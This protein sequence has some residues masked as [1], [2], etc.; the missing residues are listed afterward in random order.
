MD[1]LHFRICPSE[2]TSEERVKKMHGKVRL[3]FKLGCHTG[4]KSSN[5]VTQHCNC[6]ASILHGSNNENDDALRAKVQQLRDTMMDGKGSWDELWKNET[7][8]WDLGKPTPVL[9]AELRKQRPGTIFQRDTQH[10]GEPMRALVPGCGSAC[11]L[12]IIAKHFQMMEKNSGNRNAVP[13]VTGLDISSHSIDQARNQIIPLIKNE[14]TLIDDPVIPIGHLQKDLMLGD[15]FSQHD[16]WMH[17]HSVERKGNSEEEAKDTLITQD[18]RCDFIH[19]CTFF[20]ASPPNQRGQWA[21]RMST[22]LKPKTGK[23]LTL[24]FPALE[25]LDKDEVQLKGLPF[26]VTIKD[27]VQEL[28]PLGFQITEGP[29]KSKFTVESGTG[30]EFVCWWTCAPQKQKTMIRHF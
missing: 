20:C 7:M 8:P 21:E 6:H 12:H 10:G 25:K 28:E 1:G 15:F 2:S 19:D 4:S 22:P 3:P 29:H 30:Q 9:Q 16:N 13:V 27:H 5:K 11:D 14:E 17:E 26:P 23:L 24:I 18:I